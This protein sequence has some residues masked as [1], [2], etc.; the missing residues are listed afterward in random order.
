MIESYKYTYGFAGEGEHPSS[1]ASRT[2]AKAS[3][4]YPRI[5]SNATYNCKNNGDLLRF[6]LQ[7]EAPQYSR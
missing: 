3:D 1:G 4:T 6:H 2:S 5:R 7:A